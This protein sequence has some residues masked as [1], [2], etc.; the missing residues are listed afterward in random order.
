MSKK[1]ATQ[2]KTAAT[3]KTTSKLPVKQPA[4]KSASVKPPEKQPVKSLAVKPGTSKP[5]VKKAP[6]VTEYTSETIAEEEYVPSE[7]TKRTPPYMSQYEYC[8]LISARAAQ[9]TSRSP[10]W[11]MPKIPIEEVGSYD[12]LVIATEEIKRRLVSL[13]VRRKLPDGTTEDYLL[14]DM[15]FP[16][17]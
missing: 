13:V 17:I 4:V 10:E 11:N 12:P 3:K 14:K 16:R 1:A 7:V 2:I 15:I 8:A 5:S 9:L 6:A